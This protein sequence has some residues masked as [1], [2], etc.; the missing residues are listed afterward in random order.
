M[1]VRPAIVCF[2]LL[3]VGCQRP[4]PVSSLTPA[5]PVPSGT[6]TPNANTPQTLP[7]E[8]DPALEKGQLRAYY[9]KKYTRQEFEAVRSVIEELFPNY[10]PAEKRQAIAEILAFSYV[11]FH[12]TEH[13]KLDKNHAALRRHEKTLMDTARRYQVPPLAVMAIVSWE[14]SGGVSKVSAADAAGLG[15]MTDGAIEEAH[16]Y[17][18]QEAGRLRLEATNPAGVEPMAK[19]LESIEFRH[20]KA[21]RLAKV[22]DERFVPECNLEDMVLFFRF[23]LYQVG[24]RVDHAIGSYH[25][26]AA[27]TDD[28]LYDYLTR[29]EGQV[30]PPGADRS[31][32]LAALERR[33]VTYLTL[34]N[35]P[36]SRQ[37]LNG[38]RTM[39]G[40]VTTPENQSQALGDESDIYPWKVLG[41]LAAYRQGKEYVEQQ[42]QRYSGPQ[43]EAETRGLPVYESLAALKKA[44]QEKKLLQSR[45][46]LT[47][48][49]YRSGY[50]TEYVAYSDFITPELEGYL[51][52]LVMRWR[53][54]AN[55]PE[56]MLPVK[57][58]MNT[59]ALSVG[60][61]GLF[62]RV[63]MRGVTCLIAPQDLPEDARSG[64]RKV[65]E[66]D[67]LNDR[68]YRS[69][70]DNGDVLITLNPRFG[71][72]FLAAYNKYRADR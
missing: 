19:Y 23:L 4:G 44:I 63:Q 41:S 54:T 31:D 49:G 20:Q 71:H 62:S 56:L 14:N 10:T 32:F 51:F 37:M 50:P 40:D 45:A 27:N 11:I 38:L 15:Q 72:Q 47:D 55:Q 39:D 30:V 22:P 36:R 12:E 17:A 53:K 59:R 48:Y 13:H 25:K 29:T 18:H 52:S 58:L 34:W 21:A 68:I 1:R 28:I 61:Y 69:T 3:L 8:I 67:F 57:T 9:N 66:V 42:I 35:D 60:G 65:L 46:P 43:A 33:N 24:G 16:R 5:T 70:L 6:G 2:A 64:L 7:P 26:G